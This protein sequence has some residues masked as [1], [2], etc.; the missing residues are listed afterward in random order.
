[1]EFEEFRGWTYFETNKMGENCENL[2]KLNG[3]LVVQTS[4][5][6]FRHE[7]L[8]YFRQK[9]TL[10]RKTERLLNKTL[11]TN[12]CSHFVV[13]ILFLVRHLSQHWPMNAS[14]RSFSLQK[15]CIELKAF[16][17]EKRIRLYFF[18][19]ELEERFFPLCT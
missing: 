16:N 6:F 4:Y 2:P 19:N 10:N 8:C 18:R 12:G 9:Y 1:V 15:F 13:C 7:K 14:W 5:C 11:P 17:M 3:F